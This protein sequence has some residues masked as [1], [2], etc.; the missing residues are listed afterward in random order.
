MVH[1]EQFCK[2]APLISRL[3][4]VLASPFENVSILNL[5]LTSPLEDVSSLNLLLTSPFEDVS[6]LI[7]LCSLLPLRMSHALNL[8]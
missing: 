7:T 5:V 2:L 4:L 8:C 3:N 6:I 1:F